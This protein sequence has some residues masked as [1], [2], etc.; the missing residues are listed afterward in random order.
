MSH[1]PCQGMR[2]R[3]SNTPMKTLRRA[4]VACVLML[5]L[6]ASACTSR[7]EYGTCLGLDDDDRKDPALVYDVSVWNVVL[8]VIFV[9]TIIVPLW[10]AFKETSCPVA[11]K[12]A[13]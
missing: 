10:V 6:L 12:P 4:A 11:R 9:E 7:T 8:A 3:A 2:Q 1:R 13:R 5:S